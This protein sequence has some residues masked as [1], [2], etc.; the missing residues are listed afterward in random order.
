M[1]GT[2]TIFP[3]FNGREAIKVN[4]QSTFIVLENHA[5]KRFKLSVIEPTHAIF[6]PCLKVKHADV[7]IDRKRSILVTAVD[8]ECSR[9]LEVHSFG[10]VPVNH[11]S[12][13]PPV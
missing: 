2:H 5:R 1:F 13:E 11:G 10:D 4:V 12:I 6:I 9:C 8:L 3:A 7:S